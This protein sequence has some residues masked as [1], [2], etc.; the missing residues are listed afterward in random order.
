MCRSIGELPR[1]V[2][3]PKLDLLLIYFRW[4]VIKGVFC[5]CSLCRFLPILRAHWATIVTFLY[6]I[7]VMEYYISLPRK[8]CDV[9]SSPYVVGE[10]SRLSPR[11]CTMSNVQCIAIIRLASRVTET[12]HRA[13]SAK[14]TEAAWTL[15]ILTRIDLGLSLIWLSR[16]KLVERVIA[17]RFMKH[18]DGHTLLPARQSRQ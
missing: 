18:V 11:T 13:S 15:L 14:G 5:V 10:E 17:A 9:E 6:D 4:L 8:H 16:L 2:G 3:V 1:V 12:R 7:K